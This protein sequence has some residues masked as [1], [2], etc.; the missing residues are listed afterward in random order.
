[1]IK[2]CRPTILSASKLLLLILFLGF[3]LVSFQRLRSYEPQGREIVRLAETPLM[4]ASN[5]EAEF[6]SSS[7][8]QLD[9]E[10]ATDVS[11][12]QPLL[13]EDHPDWVALA[14]SVD[15][16][17][18]RI[19]IGTELA[20]SIEECRNQLD[21]AL[22]DG[23]RRYVDEHLSKNPKT[24]SRLTELNATW[25]RE[26]L[27][28]SNIEYE[29]TL[30]RPAGTYHQLWVQLEIDSKARGTIYQWLKRSE[31]KWRAGAVGLAGGGCVVCLSLLNVG[32]SLFA[33]KR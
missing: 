18:H 12:S 25:I 28:E 13:P 15:G 20:S 14:D 9:D 6:G 31:T 2:C 19:A 10:P 30:T 17:I 23:V 21:I 26:H 1:M 7:Q 33:K 22:V 8:I 4:R 32:L 5:G 3:M 24:T 27:M 29:A 11:S 16:E